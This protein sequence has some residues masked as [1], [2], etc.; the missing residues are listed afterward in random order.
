MTRGSATSSPLDGR[1]AGQLHESNSFGKSSRSSRLRKP[2]FLCG[3]C[4]AP[5]AMGRYS[6]SN[7]WRM[8]EVV[9]LGNARPWFPVCAGK[10][11]GGLSPCFS[12]PP[13]SPTQKGRPFEERPFCLPGVVPLTSGSIPFATLRPFLKGRSSRPEIKVLFSSSVS[14]QARPVR[15]C[16]DEGAGGH[17]SPRLRPVQAQ[18]I[19]TPLT[20]VRMAWRTASARTPRTPVGSASCSARWCAWCCGRRAAR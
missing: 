8:G 14:P 13:G 1:W 17:Y 12:V 15:S 4:G 3:R 19:V 11:G 9:S 7:R 18:R 20:P 10:P 6:I 5:V 16:E 2:R